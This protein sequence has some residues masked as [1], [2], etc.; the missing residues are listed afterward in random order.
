M[1]SLLAAVCM[2]TL[3]LA[4]GCGDACLSLAQ[5]ICS[6]QPDQVSQDA[7]NQRATQGKGIFT[8]SGEDEK[9]CQTQLNNN[10]CDCTKLTT[11]EGRVACGLS[12]TVAPTASPIS[13][14]R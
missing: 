13:S 12:F 11:A 9:F 2:L 1:K 7:C 14:A 10:A 4:A 5:Q 6:C 3:C 8:V